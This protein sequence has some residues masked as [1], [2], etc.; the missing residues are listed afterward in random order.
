VESASGGLVL[1][2]PGDV[3][4]VLDPGRVVVVVPGRV[5]ILPELP[6][7]IAFPAVIV[8]GRVVGDGPF[9]L[10]KNTT[11]TTITA[12]KIT[13]DIPNTIFLFIYRLPLF[14][15]KNNLIN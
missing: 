8:G 9:F 7:V 14:K 3:V 13:P 4:L 11:K 1:D 12:I 10:V 6:L 5:V 15:F 2:V